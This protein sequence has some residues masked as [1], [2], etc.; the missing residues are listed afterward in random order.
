MNDE[1]GVYSASL[2]EAS[3]QALKAYLERQ[4]IWDAFFTVTFRHTHKF[5]WQAITDTAKALHRSAHIARCFI[6]AEQHY[7]GGYHTHGLVAFLPVIDGSPRDYDTQMGFTKSAFNRLGWS[8]L[9]H[10]R[11]VGGVTAYCA[12]YLTKQTVEWDFYGNEWL[13]LDNHAIIKIRT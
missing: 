1:G 12:K 10:P 11:S 9:S 13:P 2:R 8:S 4:P 3:R 7:L 5:P 6:A